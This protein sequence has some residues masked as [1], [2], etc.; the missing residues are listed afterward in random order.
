MSSRRFQTT[1]TGGEHSSVSVAPQRNTLKAGNCMYMALH[2]RT[3]IRWLI[4]PRDLW[5]CVGRMFWQLL[6]RLFLHMASLCCCLS[7]ETRA[8]RFASSMKRERR[9]EWGT[10][11][12]A[13]LEVSWPLWMR[14]DT[15]SGIARRWTTA[16]LVKQLRQT[17]YAIG[18]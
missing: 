8:K 13:V 11:E 1:V 6:F 12:L 17:E 18:W 9:L 3:T 10:A 7:P 16:T 2:D 4:I 14:V 15:V 5:D